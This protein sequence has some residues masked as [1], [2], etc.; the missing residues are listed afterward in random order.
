MA[1]RPNGRRAAEACAGETGP[2]SAEAASED[3]A[4]S[5]KIGCLLL[6][7]LG[8]DTRTRE[9]SSRTRCVG[10]R[11]H[12]CVVGRASPSWLFLCLLGVHRV[13]GEPH[14]RLSRQQLD[15]VEIDH[16][17]DAMQVCGIPRLGGDFAAL[18]TLLCP[19]SPLDRDLQDFKPLCRSASTLSRFLS[20][21]PPHPG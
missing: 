4:R 15:P 19:F 1:T 9:M 17:L 7:L 3:A 6:Y 5:M 20:S 13:Y 2:T 18:Q 12:R 14:H 21:R 11:Y 8:S 10:P 16:F